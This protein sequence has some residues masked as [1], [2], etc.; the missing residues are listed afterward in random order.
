MSFW[1]LCFD[2]EL[3]A[4]S[5]NSG[6]VD[7]TFWPTWQLAVLACAMNTRTGK[8]AVA[9]CSLITANT[10]NATATNVAFSNFFFAKVPLFFYDSR[11]EDCS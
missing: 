7:P 11:G 2:F 1:R 10:A 5:P 4:L 9:R 3:L 8:S 6:T